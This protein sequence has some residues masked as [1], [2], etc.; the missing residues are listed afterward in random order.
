MTLPLLTDPSLLPPNSPKRAKATAPNKYTARHI[1]A[2]QA[3][4][5]H[6]AQTLLPLLETQLSVLKDENKCLSERIGELVGNVRGGEGVGKVLE[7]VEMGEDGGAEAELR[8]AS[9]G[10]PLERVGEGPV[11][12][13]GGVEGAEGVLTERGVAAGVDGKVGLEGVVG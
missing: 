9:G 5:T 8:V 2:L 4:I 3:Q 10:Q 6:L 7:G 13:Y 12:L 11:Q 1:R